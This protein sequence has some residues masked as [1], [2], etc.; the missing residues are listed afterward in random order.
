MRRLGLWL[1]IGVFVASAL[2][3]CVMGRDG[4]R[5]DNDARYGSSQYDRQSDPAYPQFGLPYPAPPYP[6]DDYRPSRR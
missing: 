2:S 5:H 4:G 1:A 6:R 3:G